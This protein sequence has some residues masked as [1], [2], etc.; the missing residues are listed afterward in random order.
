[1]FLLPWYILILDM[2]DR[3]GRLQ[4]KEPARLPVVA[5]DPLAPS[6]LPTP[7]SYS[8]FTEWE[9]KSNWKNDV[10]LKRYV[11]GKLLLT[12]LIMMTFGSVELL[13]ANDPSHMVHR[14][15]PTPLLMTIADND[16][17][18]P[19]DIA[20]ETFTR[21]REPKRIH[22]I[23]GGHFD[24]YSGPNFERNAAVQADFLRDNLC[25]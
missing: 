11:L 21:A 4:G 22:I 12:T 9:K 24:G 5:A 15:S 7:D 23:P 19:T 20:I 25:S 10:T 2:I 18:T 16:V 1:M 6:S 3:L 14:I 8:F 13:R 17:L